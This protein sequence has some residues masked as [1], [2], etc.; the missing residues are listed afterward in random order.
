VWWKVKDRLGSEQKEFKG[1]R[2][3]DETGHRFRKLFDLTGQVAL[4]TGAAAGFGEIISLGFADY[5]CDIAAVDLD[6]EG[7]KRTAE[8]VAALGRRSVAILADVGIPEQ[9]Q[10]MFDTAV[11]ALGTIDI[12]VNSA[13]ISQHDPAELTPLETWDR[14]IDVNLRGTF[15]CCQGA[16]RVMLKKGKGVIINF[17]SIAGEV[18]VGRGVNVYSAS[19][20]GVNALT[21]ELAIEWAP[22]G[23][24]VNAIAPCQFR[25]PGLKALMRDKQFDSKKL[26][27]TWTVNIPLGRIGEPEEMVGPALFLASNASS[28]VTGAIL[29]VDGGY[30]AR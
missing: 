11:E 8:Q 17:S 19:K 7:A 9:I 5:G 22:K 28:M 27:E 16:S 20:G 21:K 1:G 23:I 12:L 2:M 26:M 29:N 30:L 14:V 13:G 6:W 24:R 18:G 25:T 4:I 3:N 15:L 10:S